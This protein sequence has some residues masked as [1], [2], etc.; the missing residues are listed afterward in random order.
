MPRAFS[1][2]PRAVASDLNFLS[3]LTTF[4]A[5]ETLENPHQSQVCATAQ[6]KDAAKA[7]QKHPRIF[8]YNFFPW[9][10]PV[11]VVPPALALQGL[12]MQL[13][14]CKSP[15]VGMGKMKVQHYLCQDSHGR[16]QPR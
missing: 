7:H 5:G 4:F 9:S 6:L 13:M 14:I 8:R 15:L 16:A 12:Y 2:T 10:N 3:I 1:W 11:M